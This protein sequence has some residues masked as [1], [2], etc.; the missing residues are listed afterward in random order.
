[1]KRKCNCAGSCVPVSDVSRREFIGIAGLAVGASAAAAPPPVT[2]QEVAAWRK[3]ALQPDKPR[4]YLSGKHTDARMHLGG[5]GTGNFEIGADGQLTTW[6]LF[7][8][9]RDGEVPFTFGIRT[10]KAARLLQTA[11]GPDWPRVKAIEMRGEYPIARLKFIDPALPVQV[12]LEAMTPFAPLD[13]DFSSM[14]L[15][16]FTFRLRNR[17]KAAQTVDLAAFMQN[18][19]GYEADG[20]PKGLTHPRYGGNVNE[21]SVGRQAAALRMSA[22]TGAKPTLDKPRRLFTSLSTAALNQPF[23]DRPEGLRVFGLEAL[24][25][26]I[27]SGGDLSDAVVWL[28]DVSADVNPALLRACASAAAA[29]ALVLFSGGLQPLLGAYAA[30]TQGKEF[31]AERVQPPVVF[32]DFESGYGNW[33]V[34]GDAFGTEPATGTLPGQQH[35]SGFMGKRLVNT[36][37][38]ADASTGRLTSKPF[39]VERAFIR[40]LVGGGS[41]PTTQVRLQVAGKTVRAASGR[42]NE[43]LEMVT[44]DVREFV[45]K[46]ARI[47]IA[48][49]D[50]G[51][52]GHI[53]VDQIEF[54]D[55]PGSAE[56]LR[57]LS[58]LL[59]VRFAGL[60][61]DGA[62]PDGRPKLRIEGATLLA[63]AVEGAAPNGARTVTRTLGKGRVAI[64]LARLTDPGDLQNVEARQRAYR[65]LCALTGAAYTPPDGR[66]PGAPGSGE[67]TLLALSPGSTA[68]ASCGD[69]GEAWTRFTADG[70][71]DAQGGRTE[72]T[73][74][75]HTVNGAV[76]TR[77][78]LAPGASAEA[79]FA[80]AWRYPNKYNPAGVPMGTHYSVRWPSIARLEEAVRRDHAAMAQRTRAFRDLFYDATLPYWMLDCLTSQ[81]AISRH[82]GITF[83]IANGDFFGWEGSN[84]CCQPT[85]THVW[86]YE[87][88]LSR[89]FPDL[90]RIM[91]K[92]DYKHQ[93]R[94]DGGVNNR[95]DVPSPPRPTGEQP[96]ADGHA[97]CILKAY[98][99]ALNNP[100]EAWMREHWPHIKRAVEYLIDRDAAGSDG[101]ANGVLED[102]QWNTYDEALHGV[103][104]FISGYY[105]AALRAGEEWAKRVGDQGTAARF[106]AVFEKGRARQV[107]LCWDGEYF[108]QNLPGYEGMPGEVGPGCMSDQL[109]G[110]WW[111]HQLGLGYILPEAKVKSALSAV[112]RHNFKTDLT[113]WKHIPR[114]FAGDRDKGLIIVTWPKG[115]RPPHVMLYS[116]EVW[117]GIE[118][119]VA[120]HLMYEGLISEGM[121]V[122]KGARDRYDGV[123]RAPIPRNPWNEI[124]CGGHYARAMSS[125]SMLLALS[126]WR[127]DAP[128]GLVE[129]APR[130]TPERFRAPFVAAAGWGSLR[131]TRTGT[132]QRNEI[133]VAE[134]VLKVST[135]R[136]AAVGAVRTATVTCA[137][138]RIEAAHRMVDGMVEIALAKPV[139]VAA[140]RTLAVTLA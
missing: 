68:S 120:A 67:L 137:G 19:V 49:E 126:G 59:P 83:R 110:Q 20:A 88:S 31:S 16:L 138:K 93:Q 25:E 101:A 121:A 86:G 97:S 42:E 123:P 106:H 70:K 52:W 74:Q 2:E 1:M 89:L 58:T 131:Q 30:A 37:L 116:D 51:G 53:N 47:V 136:L 96:F 23:D 117:T 85:C 4:V 139:E 24:Q 128:A 112:F 140:G 132:G 92:I 15:A 33:T 28:E 65:D 105:L 119:Q 130:W 13:T 40:M 109:I 127:A 129:F 133:R 56:A 55:M 11:G 3:A 125:W 94:P 78:K 5:I 108:R 36:F 41:R 17:S 99:E 39:K 77:L 107:E 44:W 34:E 113:G 81:A 12:E 87:Q 8:T 29:G 71:L 98:R 135:L 38:K 32:E 22:R 6:Q 64:L 14:P 118:Y 43:R 103:T 72:P 91:R 62:L 82:I 7:N 80:L 54:T 10:G 63:G 48:D 134:G 69:W 122:A 124:E 76:A 73:P 90:A 102:D 21:T 57:V 75:G 115:G 95:T 50:T 27:A 18:P 26:A 46:E 100:D 104:T 114:A 60:P 84:G 61:A 9:L 79:V 35:V 45:G 111:A 66:H